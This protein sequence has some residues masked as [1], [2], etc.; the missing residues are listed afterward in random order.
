MNLPTSSAELMRDLAAVQAELAQLDRRDAQLQ[1]ALA[2]VEHDIRRCNDKL[3]RAGWRSV[4]AEALGGLLVESRVAI[5]DD[6]DKIRKRRA[7]LTERLTAIRKRLDEDARD[8]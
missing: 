1:S 2:D 8:D 7:Q 5:V 3:E 4:E 6:R